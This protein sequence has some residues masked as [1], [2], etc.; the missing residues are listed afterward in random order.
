MQYSVSFFRQVFHFSCKFRLSLTSFPEKPF[1]KEWGNTVENK[2]F[3]N[4]N[5]DKI[6]VSHTC[7]LFHLDS[8]IFLF[9]VEREKC[10]LLVL[11]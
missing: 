3:R 8:E 11:L 5:I 2:V 6:S 7:R 4:F 1:L 9:P 10:F